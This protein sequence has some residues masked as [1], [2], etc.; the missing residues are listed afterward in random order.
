MRMGDIGSGLRRSIDEV[1][2]A[3]SGN[4]P[5]GAPRPGGDN[6]GTLSSDTA[7]GHRARAQREER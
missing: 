6:S 3:D 7:T 5:P 2:K 1:T 4:H